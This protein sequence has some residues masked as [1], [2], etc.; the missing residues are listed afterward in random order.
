MW[1]A[2]LAI[3]FLALGLGD[4]LLWGHLE[5]AFGGNR[6]GGPPA[7]SV[8]P[9]GLVHWHW[10]IF[11]SCTQLA[12]MISHTRSAHDRSTTTTSSSYPSFPPPPCQLEWRPMWPF[13]TILSASLQLSLFVFFCIV[14]KGVSGEYWE[15]LRI[16]WEILICFANSCECL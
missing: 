8:Q 11:I 12:R 4:C 15:Y 10:P 2:C 3:F 13:A 7:G 9:K 14:P 5:P 16:R 1:W 6:R